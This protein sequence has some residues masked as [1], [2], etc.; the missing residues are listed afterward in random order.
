MTR[1]E[2][3]TENMA[4]IGYETLH[5]EKWDDLSHNSA[6]RVMWKGIATNMLYEVRRIWELEKNLSVT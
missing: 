5:E 4:M 1:E 6:V 2:Y 3:V